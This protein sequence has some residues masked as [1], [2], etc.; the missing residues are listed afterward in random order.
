MGKGLTILP[1]VCLV[2]PLTSRITTSVCVKLEQWSVHKK[3]PE[4]EK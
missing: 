3:E 4:S 1:K 2:L